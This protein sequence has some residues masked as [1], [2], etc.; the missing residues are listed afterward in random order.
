MVC[1]YYDFLTEVSS[2]T[3]IQINDKTI[4]ATITGKTQDRDWNNRES[5]AVT[6]A[7]TY[8]EAKS[9]FVDDAPWAIVY[10]ED[11]YMDETGETVTPEPVV[12][13]NS[14]YSVSGPI[15]DNRDGTV[16]VKMGKITDSEALAELREALNV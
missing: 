1:L 2:M 13:D 3:Y 11:S 14:D 8:E 5:K 15:T 16:T 12:Y 6:V 7:L 10:Q 4:P 9:M